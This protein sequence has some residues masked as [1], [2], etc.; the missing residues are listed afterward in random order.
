MLFITYV[1]HKFHLVKDRPHCLFG[2]TVFFKLLAPR[3]DFNFGKGRTLVGTSNASNNMVSE[4]QGTEISKGQDTKVGSN[5]TP[6]RDG[7][8]E[9]AH[10]ET[11]MT[12]YASCGC[13]RAH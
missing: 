1:F 4:G 11:L 13:T 5:P 2:P 12:R 9:L 7:V 6:D 10:L 3:P 8:P